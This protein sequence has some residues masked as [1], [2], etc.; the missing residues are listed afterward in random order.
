MVHRHCHRRPF[1]AFSRKSFAKIFYENLLLVCGIQKYRILNVGV[2][3]YK[4]IARF[5]DAQVDL[6]DSVETGLDH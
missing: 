5:S 3:V 4:L 2:S 1:N 6:V